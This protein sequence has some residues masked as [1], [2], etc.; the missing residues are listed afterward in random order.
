MT[1]K[2]K[3]ALA[4][5]EAGASYAQ[6]GSALGISRQSAH[7]L[8]QN[9]RRVQAMAADKMPKTDLEK[10]YATPAD[11]Q[12]SVV[13]VSSGRKVLDDSRTGGW[14]AA[15]VATM[16]ASARDLSDI[17]TYV[18]F[19]EEI[20]ERY[21]TYS[22]VLSTR[23][24]A[25]AALPFVVDPASPGA[26]DKKVAE[27]V[28]QVLD[29]EQVRS[30]LFDMLDA[31][32]KGFS[33]CEV[34]W[35]HRDG[36]LVPGSI[37]YVDPRWFSFDKRDGKTLL[38]NAA[39]SGSAPQ[40]LPPAKFITHLPKRKSG[41]PIRSGL[42][43]AAAW[44]HVIS[45]TTLKDWLAFVELYGQP[46]RLGKYKPGTSKED[47]AVLKRAV[48]SLGTDA[49]AIFPDSMLVEFIKDAT[50]SGSADAYERLTRY[51]DERVSML[52][53]GATLTSGT[54]NTGSGGSQALGRVH[55]EVRADILKADAAALSA[56]LMR[57]LVAP[58]VRLNFG[59]S[60]PLPRAYLQ[61]EEP[62]DL[63][64]EAE[65]VERLARAGVRLKAAE[66]RAFFGYSDPADGDEVVGGQPAEAPTL[67]GQEGRQ[68]AAIARAWSRCP[69]HGTHALA[70][71]GAAESRDVFDDEID[72]VSDAWSAVAAE[73][74]QSFAEAA[75]GAAGFDDLR[76]RLAAA[77]EQLPEQVQRLQEVFASL[78]A[79]GHLAGDQGY[80]A[81]EG[82]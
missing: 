50:V 6:V 54:S 13:S 47:I 11:T 1:P 80:D 26:R 31:L 68:A 81:A 44:L 18:S 16:L 36:R 4:L 71:S 25:V 72:A 5:R 56:T 2:Q 70:A 19:A 15:R 64:A 23:K 39:E 9:A 7:T 42:A 69:E 63:S 12:A 3:Q 51:C 21:P 43:T 78:M 52:V 45:G 59:D 40:P 41:L 73:L 67:P 14:T 79:K 10:Q 33:A 22:S 20:E 37:D 77:L 53:L 38:L 24:L 55:D 32:G 49:S 57:D 60:V 65:I 29:S 75:D 61:V 27:F 34:L 74:E 30:A 48:Q 62:E 28:K 82:K 46:V 35:T 58:L 8:V 76:D 17:R 66:V